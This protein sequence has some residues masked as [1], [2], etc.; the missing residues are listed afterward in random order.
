[1]AAAIVFQ[2]T[3]LAMPGLFSQDVFSY[4]AYGRAAAVYGLNPYIWPPSVLQDP[5]RP[6]VADIWRTYPSPYG[7]L[8][9]SVQWLIATATNGLSIADQALV[10]RALAS[11]LLLVNLALVWRLLGRLTPLSLA[12]RTAALVALAWNPV[13]LFEVAG[14]AHNDVLMVTFCLLG[15]LFFE[16]SAR[17]AR[18]GVRVGL[19]SSVAVLALGTLVKYL[20]GVGLVWLAVATGARARTWPRRLGHLFVVGL[21][22]VGIAALAFAPWLELPDSLD[23]LLNET[24]GVGYVNSLPDTLVRLLLSALDARN[25][26]ASVRVVERLLIV[27]TFAM[28]LAWETRRIWL[29]PRAS[30]VA[31]AVACSALLYV[32]LVSTSMQTWYFCLPL[33]AAMM[34]G[35]RAPVARL[36]LVASGVALPVLYLSYYLRA[37]TPGTVFVLY[38]C[39]PL[40]VVL[41]AAHSARRWGVDRKLGLRSRTQVAVWPSQQGLAPA[42]PPR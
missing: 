19:L 33:S 40:V 24:A 32:V 27:G 7:P 14:N 29:D 31:R 41:L 3:L 20:C 42:E 38:A 15:L 17:G 23:P 37:Q 34:L 13:L 11:L 6:W 12:Q 16:R 28:Y 4:I 18:S 9:V 35:L 36:A 8:W 39:V 1:M 30:S 25:A 10:Y 5:V 21:V 2:L 26:L 22:A